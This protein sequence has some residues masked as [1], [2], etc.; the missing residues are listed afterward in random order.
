MSRV[1]RSSV[2]GSA[3]PRELPLYSLAEAARH[4]HLPPA[5]LRSWVSGRTYRL[6]DGREGF[7]KPLIQLP[8]PEDSRLS[9]TNLVE[10][11]VLHALRAHHRIPMKAVREALEYASRKLGISR[12]LIRQELRAAPGELFLKE[13]GRLLSLSPAGQLAM[14]KVL[15]AYL[16][17][18]VHDAAG[19]PARL[20][21]FTL[22]DRA[23]DRRVVAIDPRVSYGRPMIARKGVSTSILTERLNAGDTV[24]ELATDYGLQEE[25]V[26][27]AIVYERAA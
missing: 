5:T 2:Y 6:A 20:Y 17:R 7:S 4:L 23:E 22:P 3:D 16:E 27:E 12:L 10:A 13:Y 8:D 19:L 14:E 24:H 9:F 25:E 26:E 15:S 18:V 1:P 21:P 11:H